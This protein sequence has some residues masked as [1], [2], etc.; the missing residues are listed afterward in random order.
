M[1]SAF[2]QILDL[3][4]KTGDKCLVLDTEGNPQYVMMSFKEYQKL[5]GDTLT[6]NDLFDKIDSDL[7]SDFKE[8]RDPT[9]YFENPD[10]LEQDRFYIE[11]VE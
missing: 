3:L 2:T 5:I 9:H 4:K 1:Q 11:P 6:G 10:Y 7:A 8:R